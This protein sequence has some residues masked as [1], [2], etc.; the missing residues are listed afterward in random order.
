[1]TGTLAGW[2]EGGQELVITAYRAEMQVGGREGGREA[3]G[4]RGGEGGREEGGREEMPQ[5]THMTGS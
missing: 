1:M 5:P 3:E 2:G 4:K